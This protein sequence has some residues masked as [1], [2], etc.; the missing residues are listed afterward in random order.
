MITLDV[1][2]RIGVSGVRGN[3]CC[4]ALLVSPVTSI[5]LPP[6]EPL[7]TAWFDGAYRCRDF[8]SLRAKVH[9]SSCR[10]EGISR[11]VVAVPRA[12]APRRGSTAGI[13]VLNI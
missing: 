1:M 13:P 3:C 10:G 12:M 11:Y 9:H 4:F 2:M 8:L 6:Y 5:E 7:G